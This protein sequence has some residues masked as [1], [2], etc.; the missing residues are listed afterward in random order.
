AVRRPVVTLGLHRLFAVESGAHGELVGA[1]GQAMERH[2]HV[3]L[4]A[5]ADR[6]E[7]DQQAQ[8]ETERGTD[9]L[10]RASPHQKLGA[11]VP[12]AVSGSL[13]TPKPTPNPTPT[14]ASATPTTVHSHQDL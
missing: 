3:F 8:G 9:R 11:R 1:V 7:R 6:P 13:R 10:R 14:P 5:A 2:H 4:I 12:S